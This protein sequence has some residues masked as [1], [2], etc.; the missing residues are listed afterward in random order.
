MFDNDCPCRSANERTEQ[1]IKKL[2][3]TVFR[4]FGSLFGSLLGAILAHLLGPLLFGG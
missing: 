3:A 1:R 2:E 4:L